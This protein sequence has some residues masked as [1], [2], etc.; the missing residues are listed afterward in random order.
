MFNGVSTNGTNN[1]QIQIGTGGTPT[2][3]GYSAQ[4]TGIASSSGATS[5]SAV[6]FPS[7]HNVAT[8]AWSGIVTLSNVSGN[9][10]VASGLL[11]NATT[12]PLTS[13]ISGTITLAG[14][15]DN[16]RIIASATGSP[17]D[18]FD[19]GSVNIMYE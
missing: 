3:S 5:S 11:G 8:Y 9:I 15:L 6:G 10:W 14:V 1:F 4:T 19:A 16:I 7:Y 17:A 12:T 2:I 18:T 13:M